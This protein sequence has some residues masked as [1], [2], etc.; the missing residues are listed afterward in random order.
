MSDFCIDM[1]RRYFK[2]I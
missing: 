1:L 2:G